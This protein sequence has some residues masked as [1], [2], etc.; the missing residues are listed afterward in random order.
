M[1]TYDDIF[2]GVAEADRRCVRCGRH[3]SE[4]KCF[5]DPEYSQVGVWLNRR[6]TEIFKYQ[7]EELLKEICEAISQC[8]ESEELWDCY[9]RENVGRAL[10]YDP[11]R[12]VVKSI[13]CADCL[14][15]EGDF[16]HYSWKDKKEKSVDNTD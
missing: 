16:N 13:E 3:I 6:F 11:G 14:Q 4:L 12:W 5:D 9:G 10:M 8:G 2:P 1:I 15:E 7:N